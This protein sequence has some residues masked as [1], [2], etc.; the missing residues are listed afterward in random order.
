VR[1]DRLGPLIFV[2][3]SPSG[4]SLAEATRPIQDINIVDWDAI[5]YYDSRTYHYNCNWKV[6]VENSLECYHCQ[7][8]H[9]GLRDVLD[10]PNYVFEVDGY[11]AITGSNKSDRKRSVSQHEMTLKEAG[12]FATDYVWPNLY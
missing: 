6:A 1:L 5:R 3:L 8:A 10:V 2:N 4:P 7:V 12:G 11:C 9:P